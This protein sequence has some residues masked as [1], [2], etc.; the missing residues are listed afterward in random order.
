MRMRV[1]GRG[2]QGRGIR[3]RG[4]GV[5]GRAQV[6]EEIQA[7]II[8]DVISGGLSLRETGQGVQLV[9]NRNTVASAVRIFQQEN[10]SCYCTVY[11]EI[12]SVIYFM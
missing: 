10:R 9:L 5:V 12:H 2:V 7:T 4:G 11:T 1:R 8:D 3:V 6:S